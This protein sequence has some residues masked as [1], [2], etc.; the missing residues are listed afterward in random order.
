MRIGL[1][2]LPTAGKTYILN[3]I[4]MLEV[5][6]GSTLLM[7]L[8]P[9]FHS[10]GETG[11]KLARERLANNLRAKDMFIM[12][13]HYSFGDNV[14][15]TEADGELYDVFIY[16]YVKPE[17]LEMRMED[18]SRN[19][20]YLEYDLN[21][22][23]NYEIDQLRKYCHE[24]DKDFYV[25]DNPEKGFL[26]DI[27]IALEFIGAIVG[28]FSCRSFAEYIVGDILRNS[29]DKE[30]VLF[31]GDKTLI[32]ED[33]SA[34][35]GYST[36]LFDGNFYT[37]F[38][39]WRH[40]A[41]LQDYLR[42]TDYSCPDIYDIQLSFNHEILSQDNNGVILTTGYVGIWKQISERMGMTL[43]SG[44]QMASETKY[45]VT[46]Y[47]QNNNIRVKAYGDSMNDYFMLLQAD[48]GYLISKGNGK[49]SRSLRN[50]QLEGI[51]IV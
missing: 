34:I 14:V 10:L 37:G 19:S 5:L 30:I 44:N 22:W 27:S 51:A 33:S 11:R 46:K 50:K 24:H 20:K 1:Y 48:E 23:Q 36:H 45:F 49:V 38:Q 18:S 41:E 40:H 9:N 2:G 4:N 8:E 3:E 12:D 21:K 28:G 31:D 47:L 7:E 29:L 43:Y 35:T 39:T 32:K 15:F 6:S 25:I 16:L 26:D 13:G 17:I 42:N